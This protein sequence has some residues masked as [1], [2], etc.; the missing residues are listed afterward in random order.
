MPGARR[1]HAQT[2]AWRRE[3]A[4]SITLEPAWRV[5]APAVHARRVWK[6]SSSLCSLLPRQHEKRGRPGL[7]ST[8][9]ASTRDDDAPTMLQQSEHV[10]VRRAALG[11]MKQSLHVSIDQDQARHLAQA[12]RPGAEFTAHPAPTMLDPEGRAMFHLVQAAL[13]FGSGWCTRFR[14]P[15]GRAN[16]LADSLRG[17]FERAGAPSA[18]LLS[19]IKPSDCERILLAGASAESAAGSEQPFGAEGAAAPELIELQARALRDLGRHLES[20]HGGQA[21]R[22]LADT[23]G[24]LQG[25]LECCSALPFFHDVQRYRGVEVPFLARS[26]RLGLELAAEFRDS[27][28]AGWSEYELYAISSDPVLIGILVAGGVLR[29]EQGIM[30]RLV[31]GEAIPAHSERE[32]ELRAA[33]IVAVELMVHALRR[34]GRPAT[35]LGVDAWLRAQ[36]GWRDAA[37]PRVRTVSY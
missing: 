36:S 10:D 21:L 6:A 16:A 35:A 14:G 22:F 3:L 9:S 37:R 23:G 17:Q 7:E 28:F 13:A 29:P 20:H 31:A 5:E 30:A 18:S 27:S 11:V 24:R 26:Q 12:W 34:D 8:A 2:R 25:L 33:A 19:R 4:R 15:E 1:G 32:I